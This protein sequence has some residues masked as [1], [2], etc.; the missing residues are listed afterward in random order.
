MITAA[1]GTYVRE[2]EIQY[3]QKYKIM[4]LKSR[5]QIKQYNYKPQT[6]VVGMICQAHNF[7]NCAQI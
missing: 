2:L 7:A 6:I 5:F 4:I 1:I 3:G